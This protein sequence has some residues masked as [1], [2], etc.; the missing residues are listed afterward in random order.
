MNAQLQAIAASD[1]LTPALTRDKQQVARQFSRAAQT[2]LSAA[3]VQQQTRE[4]LLHLCRQD[5]IGG[6]WLDIGCGP[7]ASLKALQEAGA[8]QISGLDISAGMLH[9]ARQ[10]CPDARLIQADADHL[11]LADHCVHGIFSSLMLQW[12]EYPLQTLREWARVLRPGGTLALATLLPGT[13]RELQQA[14][15]RIDQR[16]HVNRFTPLADLLKAASLSGMHLQLAERDRIT[17][18]YASINDLL[19]GLKAIGAT[20][21]NAG[22]NPGLGGRQA[23]QNLASAY[24]VTVNEQGSTCYPLSYEVQWLIFRRY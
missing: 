13:Q 10:H 18:Q 2:Y 24:P 14:W 22:R 15:Q 17:D 7:A 4:H 20:N 12:S 23:L 8:Q 3:T 6:H 11:P 9:A 1:V 16:P 5:G 19:R 21:V